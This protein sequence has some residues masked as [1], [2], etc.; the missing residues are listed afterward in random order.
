MGIQFWKNKKGGVAA[1]YSRPNSRK[2]FIIIGAS[3]ILIAVILSAYL[4][5]KKSNLKVAEQRQKIEEARQQRMSAAAWSRVSFFENL[6]I[7]VTFALP[8]YLE[9]NYRLIKEADKA[10][11]LYIKDP[12]KPM[13]LF[14]IKVFG[15]G[16]YQ[17]SEGELELVSDCKGFSFSYRLYEPS[18][19][20]GE[21]KE[22]FGQVIYD[23]EYF[24][25]NEG[26]FQ[27]RNR[28]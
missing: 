18:S 13:P 20:E 8:D 21:D 6:P 12:T 1:N 4:M 25:K 19:Y 17:P 5:V 7:N 23:I 9:G 28:E 11:F 15:A 2:V 3:L 24:L 26:Y 27:C 10:S 14:Y 16:G 22:A